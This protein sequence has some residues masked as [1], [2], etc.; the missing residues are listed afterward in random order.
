L[1]KDGDKAAFVNDNAQYGDEIIP[2][3]FILIELAQQA[4]FNLIKAYSLKQQKGNSSQH[5]K[6][7][8]ER[9]CE[10]VL[11]SWK[12]PNLN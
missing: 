3:D 8:E 4:S 7:L 11:S 2:V 10:K 12:S 1:S 9:R 6:K 5:T